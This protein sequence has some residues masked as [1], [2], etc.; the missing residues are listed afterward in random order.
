MRIYAISDGFIL[1][2]RDHV[3]CW[4]AAC[5]MLIPDRLFAFS[6]ISPTEIMLN[7][8]SWYCVFRLAKS[9]VRHTQTN[10]TYIRI[11]AKVELIVCN[12]CTAVNCKSATCTGLIEIDADFKVS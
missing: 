9:F 11:A 6:E 12:Y 3:L 10:F 7:V 8:Q 1:D 5:L 2:V 4:R